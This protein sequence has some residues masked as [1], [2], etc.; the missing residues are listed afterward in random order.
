MNITF[1]LT[2]YCPFD[3]SFTSIHSFLSNFDRVE[4]LNNLDFYGVPFY[5]TCLMMMMMMMMM[6]C[7]CGMFDRQKMFSLISSWN[8][9]Q[10]SSS[11]RI[12]D[13]LQA[14]FEPAQN[15]SSGF[16]E[17]SCAVVIT[18]T[19]WWHRLLYGNRVKIFQFKAKTLK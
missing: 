7:I 4:S 8:H 5:N 15:L 6:N 12:S 2:E 3:K 13:M 17:W 10:K 1:L 9:C 18:T 11:S 19:P 16:V 14:G